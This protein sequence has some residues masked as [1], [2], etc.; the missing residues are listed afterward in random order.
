MTIDQTVW[1]DWQTGVEYWSFGVSTVVQWTRGGDTGYVAES[2]ATAVAEFNEALALT[3]VMS[4]PAATRR[5]ALIEQVT[6]PTT[7]DGTTRY[8]TSMQQFA[9]G[10]YFGDVAPYEWPAPPMPAGAILGSYE[11]E[12][13]STGAAGTYLGGARLNVANEGI[14]ND[15]PAVFDVRQELRVLNASR[16]ALATPRSYDA[17]GPTVFSFGPTSSS[18]GWFDGDPPA[19]VVD[20]SQY[21]DPTTGE[22]AL[23]TAAYVV[24][25][26]PPAVG[27]PYDQDNYRGSESFFEVRMEYQFR[28]PRYRW[29]LDP[30]PFPTF[31]TDGLSGDLLDTGQR[32]S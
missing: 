14:T 28:T 26:T 16:S 5:F 25:W 22:V 11:Y 9:A 17:S 32:F 18:I 13:A 10:F 24:S 31:V 4:A 30:N 19:P 7:P 1:G 29:Q 6:R 23:T 15:A 8:Q 2:T 21:A 27:V 3:G 12:G 20:V